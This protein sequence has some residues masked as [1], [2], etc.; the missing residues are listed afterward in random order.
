MATKDTL[1]N[2]VNDPTSVSENYRMLVESSMW[3]MIRQE[4]D[5]LLSDSDWT[6]MPDSALSD[7][8]RQLWKEYRQEL[9]DL[10]ETQSPSMDA[11]QFITNVVYPS[12]PTG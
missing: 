7:E 9:R 1:E 4:R 12:K 2:W 6:Q 8:K 5:S 11:D 10:T 3:T